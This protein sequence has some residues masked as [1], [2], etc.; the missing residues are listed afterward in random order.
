MPIINDCLNQFREINNLND[1]NLEIM[2][3]LSDSKETINFLRD[4]ENEDI[5]DWLECTEE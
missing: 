3:I 4:H 2:E 1:L 5:Y